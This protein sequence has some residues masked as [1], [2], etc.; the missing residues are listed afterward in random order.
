[1]I[2]E[3]KN[4]QIVYEHYLSIVNNLPKKKHIKDEEDNF[5]ILIKKFKDLINKYEE[6][7]QSEQSEKINY[8]KE[9]TEL[10][11]DNITKIADTIRELK[12]V[13]NAIE[14]NDN[15]GT[16]KL[17]QDNYNLNQLQVQVLGTENKIISYIK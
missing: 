5:F 10:Y 4:Y 17:I 7:E 3:V 2:T 14:Y 16:Y 12:Y 6:S 1:M 15:N 13:Y 9:A 8:L 11:I